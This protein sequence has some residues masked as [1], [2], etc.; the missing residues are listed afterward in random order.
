[1]ADTMNLGSGLEN[2]YKWLQDG[3][4]LGLDL[5]SLFANNSTLLESVQVYEE[6][7][8]QSLEPYGYRGFIFY[9]SYWGVYETLK[10]VDSAL[11]L[12]FLETLIDYGVKNQL[13]PD[14]INPLIKALMLGPMKAI[15]KAWVNYLRKSANR[16][17]EKRD[18][19]Q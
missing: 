14:D 15:D 8:A 9:P 5:L 4:N 13:P 6:K 7:K 12:E 16:G 10:D 17:K 18:G 3:E 2:Y 1:M 19:D 11:S